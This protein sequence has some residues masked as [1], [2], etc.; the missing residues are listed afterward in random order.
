MKDMGCVLLSTEIGNIVRTGND[1]NVLG[2]LPLDPKADV[3]C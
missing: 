2:D 3:L 1:N